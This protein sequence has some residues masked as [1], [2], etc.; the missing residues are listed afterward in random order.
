MGIMETSLALLDEMKIRRT[1]HND[2]WWFAVE[3]VCG[4]LMDSPDGGAFWWKL[5]QGLRAEGCEVATLCHALEFLAIDGTVR[6]VD[7]VTIEGIF[8]IV[9]SISSPKA[10][11]FKRWLAEV[12]RVRKKRQGSKTD[13]DSIFL[14]LGE[15]AT[16]EI[17]RKRDAQGFVENEAA[18]RKGVGIAREAR[19]RLE[20]ETGVVVTAGNYLD[21]PE[22]WKLL[23]ERKQE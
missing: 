17:A 3:D 13:L 10:E 20:R 8:R 2:E 15:A 12:G 4:A 21:G 23:Q 14:M 19:E 6:H 5:K 9:Q 7:C 16:V 22:G 1:L 18:T 11:V